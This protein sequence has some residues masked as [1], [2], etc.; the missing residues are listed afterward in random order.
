MKRTFL[1]RGKR[2]ARTKFKRRVHVD[3]AQNSQLNRLR[4]RRSARTVLKAGRRMKEWARVWA[5]LKPRFEAAGRVRCE[6]DFL[7][8]D[9]RGPLDP[10]HS[11]KRSK[12][13]DLD[14]YAVGLACR[15]IHDYLDGVYVYP[16]L[17]RRMDHEDMETAVWQAI[18]ANGGVILPERK[19]A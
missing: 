19:A 18:E 3:A 16:P 8:H 9:C 15:T 12:M 10:A 14:I 1:K 11:K 17:G 4:K 13:Q 7:K 6:F 5:W 2:I